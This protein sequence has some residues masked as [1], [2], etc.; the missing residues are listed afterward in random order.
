MAAGKGTRLY[1]LTA[2]TPKTLV[3][4]HGKRMIDTV[5]DGLLHQGIEEI[6][7]VVGYLKEQF[8]VLLEKYPNLH[9]IE[10]PYYDRCNNISSLYVARDYLED[11]IILDGDQYIYNEAI[12]TPYFEKSSY[13]CVKINQPT[14]EW[15]LTVENNQVISC[16]RNGGNDGYQLYS[17]SRWT[18]E[19]GHK[20][21]KHL[22]IEFEEKHNDQIYWDDVALF[23]Y[24]EAYNLGVI[25]MQATDIVEIDDF[26]ELKSIDPSYQILKV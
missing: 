24:P 13:N 2:T 6:Y 23:C 18:K 12:L 3:K 11:V 20:L 14:H 8:Y 25:E 10:N 5:I 26:E 1:P 21:R 7:I 4:V 15:V 9:F 22:E 17:V 19:D 16:A